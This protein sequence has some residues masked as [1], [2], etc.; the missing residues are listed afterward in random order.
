MAYQVREERPL[1][2]PPTPPITPKTIQPSPTLFALSTSISPATAVSAA[3][4]VSPATPIPPCSQRLPDSGYLT[5]INKQ[6]PISSAYTPPDL[7]ALSP[8]LPWRIVWGAQTMRQEAANALAQMTSQMVAEG[9][10]P[11]ILSAYRSFNE[12]AAAYAKWQAEQPTRA[13]IISARPGSSEHQLGTTV[14]F[15]SPELAYWVGPAIQFHPLFADTSE[16]RWLTAHAHNYG[17][18]LSYPAHGFET[19]G[20]VYEP[21]HYRYV[22][23]DT[24]V[25]LQ[26]SGQFLLQWQLQTQP[27][28]CLP[29]S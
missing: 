4:A 8:L 14:D 9:L 7:V 13:D 2:Q 18:T 29:D 21:W 26:Q 11:Q 19:T 3:T 23:V 1:P 20:Y 12:Q 6:Y 15:G 28:P 22:G 16:G 10:H 24:A 5:Y 27:A 25:A 17:F